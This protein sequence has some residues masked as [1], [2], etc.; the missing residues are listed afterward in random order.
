MAARLARSKA[1]VVVP[2]EEPDGEARELQH[3][4]VLVRDNV[5]TLRLGAEVL[6]TREHVTRVVPN[7]RRSWK[8]YFDGGDESEFWTVTDERRACC[9]GR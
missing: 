9:G 8:L 1:T 7:G 3:V 2:P 6:L 5:A 4:S